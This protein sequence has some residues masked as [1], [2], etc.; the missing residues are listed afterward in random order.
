MNHHIS[1]VSEYVVYKSEA[2]RYRSEHRVLSLYYKDQGFYKLICYRYTPKY[3][4]DFTY[5]FNINN[6][7]KIALILLAG[8]LI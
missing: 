5:N 7:K 3:L 4:K 8:M 2:H 6:S 1:L